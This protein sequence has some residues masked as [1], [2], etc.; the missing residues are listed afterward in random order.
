[1]KQK[2]EDTLPK[3]ELEVLNVLDL[4]RYNKEELQQ[5]IIHYVS[6]HDYEKF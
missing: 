6:E 5:K 4:S 3:D 1:V 2:K